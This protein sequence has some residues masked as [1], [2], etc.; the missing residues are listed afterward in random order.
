MIPNNMGTIQSICGVLKLA[1]TYSKT[2]MET[3]KQYVKYVQT[4]KT[5]KKKKTLWPLFMD[6]V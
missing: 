2:T 5:L 6:G 1:F 3:S 4:V